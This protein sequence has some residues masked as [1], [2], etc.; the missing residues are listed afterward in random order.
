MSAWANWGGVLA[1]FAEHY[2]VI[3]PDLPGYGRSHVPSLDRDYA[4][5]AIEAIDHVLAAEGVERVHIVGNS[6]GG[7]LATRFAL[8]TP[9]RAGRLVLMG[10]GGVGFP[11]FGPQPTEGIKRLVEFTTDPTR[12]KLVAWMESMVG[13]RSFLTEEHIERRWQAATAPQALTFTRDFYAAAMRHARAGT[14]APLWT[15][16]GELRHH[17]LITY[18]RDDRVTPLESA[19]LPL[20]LIANAEL[21]VFARACHWAMLERR[22]EFERIVLEYLGHG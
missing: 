18:G 2:R 7:M 21:H 17:V 22:E 11:L 14:A 4:A 3:A 12:D 1:A 16:L 10:P 19:F 5:V 15:R 9:A 13:D 8:D 20:R 6:L